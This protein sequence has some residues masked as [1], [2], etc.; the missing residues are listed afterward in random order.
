MTNLAAI[1][2]AQALINPN[3]YGNY[4]VYPDGSIYDAEDYTIDELI[5]DGHSDDCIETPL[6]HD[7]DG[8][9]YVPGQFK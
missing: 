5:L 7:Q 1:M 2:R 6:P 8:N 9:P 4:F 3:V